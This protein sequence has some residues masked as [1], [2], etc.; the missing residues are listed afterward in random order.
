MEL[1]P[2]LKELAGHGAGEEE[3]EG[4]VFA[5][6]AQGECEGYADEQGDGAECAVDEE[7][8]ELA[9]VKQGRG[10]RQD[11]GVAQNEAGVADEADRGGTLIGGAGFDLGADRDGEVAGLD[12]LVWDG[13]LEDVA[14][15]GQAPCGKVR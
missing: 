4:E 10:F 6:A 12:G 15:R 3:A 11:G 8:G 2:D 14:A 5:L 13:A 1:R 7:G 9:E